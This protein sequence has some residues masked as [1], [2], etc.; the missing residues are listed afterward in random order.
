MRRQG[1]HQRQRFLSAAITG[2]VAAV[3]MVVAL[4]AVPRVDVAVGSWL[5]APPVRVAHVFLESAS[6]SSAQRSVNGGPAM[7]ALVPRP[8]A[9]ASGGRSDGD[10]LATVIDPGLRFNMV[11]FVCSRGG[12]GR[13]TIR[14]R[15]AGDDGPWSPWRTL[16]FELLRGDDG[17]RRLVSDPQWVGSA[18]RLQA[19]GPAT[20]TV[21][22]T[23]VNTL[24]DATASDRVASALR[25]AALAVAG[26]APVDEALAA[27]D[28]P[29]IVTRA[30][31]GADESWRR[32]SP[33]Y[34][35]V[36][37]AVVHHTASGNDYTRSQAA[38]V[39]RAV[40]YYHA[41]VCRFYDIGYN[42][43]VDR[44]GTVYEGRKGG[45]TR[46]VRGAQALGFN[47]SSTG[48]SVIGD[49]SSSLP[50]T[51]AVAAL[52]R[53]LAWKLDVHHVDPGAWTSAY[54]SDTDKFKGGTTVDVR[55]ISAHRDVCNTACPGA[56]FAAALP[57]VR[58]V[59]ADTGLPKLYAFNARP[60]V[61]SPNGDGVADETLVEFIASGPVDWTVT[62]ARPGGVAVRS[63][64][65]SGTSVSLAW[66]GTDEAGATMPDGK[67]V[68]VASAA[69]VEGTAR[70][71]RTTVRIDTAVPVVAIDGVAPTVLNPSGGVVDTRSRVRYSLSETCVAKVVVRDP[72][73]KAVDVVQGWTAVAAGPQTAV[74][75]GRI[76]SGSR[77]VRAGDGRYRVEITAR[78]AAGNTAMKA[79]P[80][81][82]DRTLRVPPDILSFSP[83]GDGRKD[84]T[85]LEFR[86]TRTADV[87]VAV[88]CPRGTVSTRSWKALAAG[89]HESAWDGLW[90]NGGVYDGR[91]TLLLTAVAAGQ[92]SRA[93]AAVV[94][95]TGPPR[96]TLK[97]TRTAVRR[98][99]TAVATCRIAD[100]LG[101]R[102]TVTIVVRAPRRRIVARSIKRNVVVGG[103]W[104][105]RL[106]PLRRGT[107]T[108]RFSVID[109][110]G[111]RRASAATWYVRSR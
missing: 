58:R 39:V 32:R 41:K 88:T 7:T 20:R 67:Y 37:F 62:I 16:R 109:A 45:M 15:V 36:R 102:A 53:L 89:K 68:M 1:S 54:C 64:A 65:G 19:R 69:S 105:Y 26:L 59:V 11:G 87:T 63:S 70:P 51:A 40:Y 44:F 103:S 10:V 82:V 46:A 55:S 12:G 107:Y 28:R 77:R 100:N 86:T 72:A 21:R 47:S 6:G 5:A 33:A 104:K 90:P 2:A 99:R 92:T 79:V 106:R 14:Y 57:A 52:E 22:A 43:L 96:L 78:D 73:G 29:A 95:D 110:A 31:W 8:V 101:A 111:N 98:G 48:V 84:T 61:F 66:D 97:R 71:C 23:F 93:G 30:R 9:G 42:F 24:G 27:T 18:R 13:P 85:L 81:R 60:P 91:Y 108:V 4:M 34:G 35:T 25:G 49:Y 3:C 17:V 38:A 83:N 94:V 80:L 75:D 50:P 76:S 56:A 74:W